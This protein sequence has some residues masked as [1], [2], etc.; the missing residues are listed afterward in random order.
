MV[1]TD[2][3]EKVITRQSSFFYLKSSYAALWRDSNKIYQLGMSE[4]T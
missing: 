3:N 1:K 2:Q 4:I